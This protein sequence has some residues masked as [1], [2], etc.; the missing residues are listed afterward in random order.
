M[1]IGIDAVELLG[2]LRERGYIK[3]PASVIEIGA[4]QLS[5]TF[6]DGQ[7]II[8]K[9]GELFGVRKKFELPDIKRTHTVHGKLDHLD[10][11]A[12]LARTFYEWLGF[13]YAAIDVDGSPGSIPLDLNHDAAP[14]S[15]KG[16]YQLVTN[17]GTTEHIANQLNAF[18]VIH[19]LTAPGGLMF[20]EVPAQ[21]MFNHGLINYN[22][23]FFWMLARSNAYETLHLDFLGDDAY[24]NLPQNI[25][26]KIVPH[27][28]SIEQR[29]ANYRAMDSKLVVVL[30]KAID[31]PYVPPLDL[32]SED[33]KALGLDLQAF[34]YMTD[35]KAQFDHYLPSFVRT[36][37]KKT[38]ATRLAGSILRR[39]RIAG[40]IVRHRR[41]KTH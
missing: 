34:D 1:G 7:S 35:M 8:D 25:V 14:D 22:P 9:T 31:V 18:R 3:T 6:R 17:F 26:D 2:A 38:H 33:T 24:Y 5:H 4:Q 37:L 21:G 20:H 39:P 41:E 12:P 23:K 27:Q 36:V 29:R 16:R 19:D 10:P 30:Q 13:R 28:P 15:E 32:A 11:G 40:W